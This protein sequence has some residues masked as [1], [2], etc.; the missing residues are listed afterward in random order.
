[1]P[2]RMPPLSIIFIFVV[3][4]AVIASAAFTS[5]PAG[6][7]DTLSSTNP[8]ATQPTGGTSAST[9]DTTVPEPSVPDATVTEPSAPETE[10][11]A[12]NK[13]Y[14]NL[15]VSGLTARDS[16]VYDCRTGEY[17]H[18][19]GDPH[20]LIYPASVTKVFTIYVA[21]MYLTPDEEVKVG[22][23]LTTVPSDSSIALLN[24]GDVLSVADLIRGM[25]LPSGGDAAR[26]LAVA[27]GK[28]L[29]G[30]TDKTEFFYFNCFVEEMN[31]QARIL[32]MTD[33]HFVN[34]DGYHDN[35]HYI[36]MADAVRMAQLC[37][38]VP[39]IM[40]IASTRVYTAKVINTG[41]EILWVNTNKMLSEREY[42]DLYSSQVVGLKTGYTSDAGGCMLSIF[43]VE[44]GYQIVGVFGCDGRDPRFTDTLKLFKAANA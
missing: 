13:T 19:S 12:P 23:I 41:R 6:L 16:F 15:E 40:E 42:P 18:L 43:K 28:K 7:G 9:P 37:M 3:V 33:S 39:L 20:R 14:P 2:K 1:M 34:S 21:L 22:E 38:E 35:D 17:I 36:S 29:D 31:R 27:A 25:L 26:V 44:G 8:S 32:G 30:T 10:S 24:K 11:T 5:V 4:L